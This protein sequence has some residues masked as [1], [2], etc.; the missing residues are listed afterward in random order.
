MTSP[1]P[2]SGLLILL[3]LVSPA[4]LAAT[5][6]PGVDVAEE[7][8]PVVVPDEL[9][10][11]PPYLPKA[12]VE[13]ELTLAGSSAM[14]QLAHLWGDGLRLLHNTTSAARHRSMRRAG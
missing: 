9:A 2:R 10:A 5:S 4:A 3:C 8:A 11:L 7:P 6:E 1:A 14:T 13:G 12:P